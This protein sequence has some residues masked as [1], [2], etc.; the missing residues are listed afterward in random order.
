MR[1]SDRGGP[2]EHLLTVEDGLPWGPQ[3]LPGGEAVLFTVAK[4]MTRLADA[5]VEGW[6]KADVVVQ[7]L[8][9]GQRQTLIE[10]GTAATYVPTGHLVY[11]ASGT[12][13]AVGFD[14]KRLPRHRRTLCLSF[15]A[16]GARLYPAQGR[17]YSEYP[18]PVHSSM[19]PGRSSR[20]RSSASWP[21]S[22]AK[23]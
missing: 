18:I 17:C 21:S 14:V 3:I 9:S 2:P 6:A 12:L 8:K 15:R 13:F 19:C 10:G 16:S 20:H 4:G 22:T 23:V 7:S 5:T 1:V 11:G